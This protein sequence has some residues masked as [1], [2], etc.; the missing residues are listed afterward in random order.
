VQDAVDFLTSLGSNI[1][2]NIS[3]CV[4]RF[5]NSP[6]GK[7]VFTSQ[8]TGATNSGSVGSLVE[9]VGALLAECIGIARCSTA[10]RRTISRRRL[11]LSVDLAIETLT[12]SLLYQR[13]FP[14]MCHAG[15][16]DSSKLHGNIERLRRRGVT[17]EALGADAVLEAVNL[18]PA[19]VVLEKLRMCTSPLEVLSVVLGFVD[20]V[21]QCTPPSLRTSLSADSL[22]PLLQHTIASSSMALDEECLLMAYLE[23]MERFPSMLMER[24]DSEAE[25]KL[26]SFRVSV[27]SLVMDGG[28]AGAPS[29]PTKLERHLPGSQPE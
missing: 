1:V 29:P 19:R 10:N 9:V 6:K 13:I 12:H 11:Q 5:R 15:K 2:D 17:R 4:S 22:I 27:E 24:L 3:S 25:Y 7:A 23:Y 8:Q 21:V 18:L 16:L 20:E 28:G 14:Q 26:V